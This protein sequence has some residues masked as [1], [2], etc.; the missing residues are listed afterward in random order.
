MQPL[1]RNPDEVLQANGEGFRLIG[2]EV[3]ER[4]AYQRAEYVR[5]QFVGRKWVAVDADQQRNGRAQKSNDAVA[6]HR[7]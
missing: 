3:S 2:Q 6:A 1:S 7:R 5:V 4:V